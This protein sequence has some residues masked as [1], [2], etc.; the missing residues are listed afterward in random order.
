MAYV[1]RGILKCAGVRKND[2]LSNTY[3][4]CKNGL[5]DRYFLNLNL[6][7]DGEITVNFFGKNLIEIKVHRTMEIVTGAVPGVIMPIF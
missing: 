4:L 1:K 5:N 3:K 6:R 7:N 2:C